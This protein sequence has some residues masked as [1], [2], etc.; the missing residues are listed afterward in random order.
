MYPSS[1]SVKSCLCKRE[2]G[3]ASL[4]CVTNLCTVVIEDEETQ[5]PGTGKSPNMNV[6]CWNSLLRDREVWSVEVSR[7]NE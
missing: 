4:N 7:R 5:K 3:V 6:T 2:E 1:F